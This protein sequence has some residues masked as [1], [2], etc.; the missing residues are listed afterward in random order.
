M[1]Y[2]FFRRGKFY[3]LPMANI[4]AGSAAMATPKP[5]FLIVILPLLKALFTK[6]I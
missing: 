1:N 6:S 2:I 3:I 4:T 5:T